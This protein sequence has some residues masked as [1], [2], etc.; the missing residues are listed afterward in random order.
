MLFSPM[1]GCLWSSLLR[2]LNP[3]GRFA[4]SPSISGD[5]C[6]MSSTDRWLWDYAWLAEG[7][8]PLTI[9]YKAN[10]LLRTCSAH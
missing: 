4:V 7:D 10:S 6:E 1:I 8:F 5:I 3:M 9:L 2:R